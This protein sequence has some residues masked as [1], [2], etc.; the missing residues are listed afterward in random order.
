MR[1]PCIRREK[2][3][4]STFFIRAHLSYVIGVSIVEA[5]AVICFAFF[6]SYSFQLCL[7][8]YAASAGTD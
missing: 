6:V 8:I 7:D 3:M 2:N 1:N 4:E 5:N